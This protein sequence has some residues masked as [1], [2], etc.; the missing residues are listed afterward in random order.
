MATR[1]R[2]RKLRQLLT[3]LVAASHASAGDLSW[4]DVRVR[5][6]RNRIYLGEPGEFNRCENYN[7]RWANLQ[8]A[9]TIEETG[10]VLTQQ[11][12]PA[13][14]SSIEGG[15]TVRNRRG[16]EKLRLAGHQQHKS[17]KKL[18]QECAIPPWRRDKLPLIYCNGEL[19]G[20]VG[21]GFAG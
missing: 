19:I 13:A 9:L 5:K 11:D 16:G 18:F 1:C 8:Y 14:C 3:D 10:Q 20:I 15:L 4:G 12:I 17:V 2:R 21:I 6:Y 7:Y